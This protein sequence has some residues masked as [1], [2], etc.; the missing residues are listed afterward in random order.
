MN[1]SSNA[2]TIQQIALVMMKI[3]VCRW[4]VLHTTEI[5]NALFEIASDVY[6]RQK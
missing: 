3:V 6:K 2:F 4:A 1:G 5:L